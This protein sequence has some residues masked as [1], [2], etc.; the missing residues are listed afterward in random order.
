MLRTCSIEGC[1]TK[2]YAMGWCNKHWSR[3]RKH[4]DPLLGARTVRLCSIEGCDRKHLRNGF[5]NMHDFRNRK[6]GDPH[7]KS[8]AWNGDLKK[9]LQEI[10]LTHESDDC[11]FWP[12]SVI[13]GGYG[14]FKENGKGVSA[15]R[16]VC[17]QTHGPAP[18]D[19]H[20]SAHSCGNGRCLNKKH[21]R[22]ATPK[23]NT[24]DKI[25]HGTI[26]RGSKSGSA[27]LNE[28]QVKEIRRLYGSMSQTKIAAQFGVA[29]QT[30]SSIVLGQSWGWMR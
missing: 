28:Q 7:H 24:A 30:V 4:G 20:E 29:N 8:K 3:W 15:N 13:P 23:E 22:W 18:T 14:R 27:K 10:A 12:F 5:C 21:L 9:W 2:H 11:L 1:A 6:F 25:V 16:W 26:A 19:I 17:E